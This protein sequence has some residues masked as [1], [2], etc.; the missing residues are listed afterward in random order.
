MSAYISFW[1]SYISA[2]NDPQQISDVNSL[3]SGVAPPFLLQTHS[4][5]SVAAGSSSITSDYG[6]DTPYEVSELGTPRHGDDNHANLAMEHLTSD[7]DLDDSIDRSVKFGLFN[8][9]FIRENLER[10]SRRQISGR[11]NANP[12]DRDQT[13]EYTSGSKPLCMDGTEFFLEPEES[14]R[15]GHARR[16][17]TESFGSDTSSLR[18]G[19]LFGDGSHNLPESSEAPRSADTF[20]NSD[21]KFSRALLAVF[22]YDERQK[23][24]RVLI[25]LQQR[26]GTAKTDIEDLISRLNQEIAVRQFLTTKV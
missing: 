11:S 17:S 23:L 26:L 1:L 12:L 21:L 8:Q 19:N 3:T 20:D 14:K 16:P 4:D 22:P 6:N 2:F 13:S 25:T 5:L 24:N 10:L 15:D 18:V 7:Q 9:K